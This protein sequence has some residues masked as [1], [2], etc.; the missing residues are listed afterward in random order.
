MTE[1]EYLAYIDMFNAACAGD[2]TGFAAF[3]DRYYEPDAMFEYIPNTTRNS[4]AVFVLSM[5]S[6]DTP[7]GSL[8][9]AIE[10]VFG[11]TIASILMWLFLL[12]AEPWI[13][14]QHSA[15]RKGIAAPISTEED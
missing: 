2:G 5:V 11:I 6:G 12:G 13:R 14:T 9:P 15:D 7:Q 10:V 1:A 4:G 3:F 8:L